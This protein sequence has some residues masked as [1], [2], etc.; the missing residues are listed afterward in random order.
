MS[1]P[2]RVLQILYPLPLRYSRLGES[3]E[4]ASTE[5]D[6]LKYL[7]GPL[8]LSFVLSLTLISL[9]TL[10]MALWASIYLAFSEPSKLVT[11][12]PV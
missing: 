1:S 5:Y 11:S 9:M 4:S 3:V 2:S 12:K 7:R 6:R 10:L 8:T